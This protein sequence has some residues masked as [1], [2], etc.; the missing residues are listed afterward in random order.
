MILG[1]QMYLVVL[2]NMNMLDCP[3]YRIGKNTLSLDQQFNLL[4]PRQ[5]LLMESA[6]RYSGRER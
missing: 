2:V 1:M 5:H 4:L 6:G 3:V